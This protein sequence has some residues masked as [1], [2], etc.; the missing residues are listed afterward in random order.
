[1]F[2]EHQSVRIAD[3]GY[4][5]TRN[6]EILLLFFFFC[7]FLKSPTLALWAISFDSLCLL[8]QMV[9]T[10]KIRFWSIK[11]Q[12]FLALDINWLNW[13]LTLKICIMLTLQ[14]KLNNPLLQAKTY[15]SILK[16]FYNDKKIPLIPPLLI[17]DKFVTDIQ[18]KEIFLLANFCPWKITVCF[19]LTNGS[20]PRQ[21]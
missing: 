13:S 5:K 9:D 20:W 1:M 3:I 12:E 17:V 19:Q 7:W 6:T 2:D 16:T 21:D 18:A 4:L 14:K 8:L 10:A 11:A 15:L